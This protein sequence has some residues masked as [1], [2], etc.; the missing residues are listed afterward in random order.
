[1]DEHE[2]RVSQLLHAGVPEPRRVL[3]GADVRALDDRGQVESARS[4]RPAPSPRRWL[5]PPLAAVVVLMV[6][7]TTA[8]VLLVNTGNRTGPAAPIA[9]VGSTARPSATPAPA[10]PAQRRP[11][12]KPTSPKPTSP[13]PSGSSPASSSPAALATCTTGQLRLTMAGATEGAAGT[14]YTPFALTN[15]ATTSC[16]MQGY[17]GVSLLDPTGA[18][19]GRPAA[20]RPDRRHDRGAGRR[21]GHVHDRGQRRHPGRVSDA[22]ALDPAPGLP[23]E[24]DRGATPAVHER[25][26]H[27][28]LVT[29]VSRG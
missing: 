17:P 28:R 22:A 12:R 10:R 1:M 21:R 8:A 16:L 20:G 14:S 19:V 29:S 26:V 7:A 5:L 4:A 24:P 18:I 27:G 13:S 3:R 25:I 11:A 2:R 15:T 23:A 6:G 9:P